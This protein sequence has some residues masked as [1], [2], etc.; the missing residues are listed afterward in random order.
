MVSIISS[1]LRNTSILAK[2]LKANSI[3]VTFG[4]SNKNYLTDYLKEVYFLLN[5]YSYKSQISSSLVHESVTNPD[6]S[7]GERRSTD[8]F[9]KSC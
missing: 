7:S 3:N 5:S 6:Q 1:N 8:L 9:S 2:S 4:D